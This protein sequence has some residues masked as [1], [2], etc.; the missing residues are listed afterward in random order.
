MFGACFLPRSA[1]GEG[2]QQMPEVQKLSLEKLPKSDHC[3]T[4]WEV[5]RLLMSS[6]SGIFG[7]IISYID[8][9]VVAN[10]C[11]FAKVK[12]EHTTITSV[13]PKFWLTCQAQLDAETAV[14]LQ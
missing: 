13:K 14:Q 4:L 7:V 9:L 3:R 1:D 2:N 6:M 5:S 10:T 11:S 12:L 8:P